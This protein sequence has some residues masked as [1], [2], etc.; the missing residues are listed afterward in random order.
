MTETT[1]VHEHPVQGQDEEKKE[2]CCD[3]EQTAEEHRKSSPDGKCCI[4]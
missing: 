2:M 4:D 3:G 1:H